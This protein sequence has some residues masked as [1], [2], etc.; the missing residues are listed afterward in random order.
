MQKNEFTNAK[1][2]GAYKDSNGNYY[3]NE[4]HRMVATYKYYQLTGSDK[5][6]NLII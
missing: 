3:M 2:L 1:V 4:G 5:C 6:I